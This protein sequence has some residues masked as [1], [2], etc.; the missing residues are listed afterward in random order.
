MG[1]TWGSIRPYLALLAASTPQ[2]D[3][4]RARLT[5]FLRFDPAQ[6]ELTLLNVSCYTHNSPFHRRYAMSILASSPLSTVNNGEMRTLSPTFSTLIAPM[7]AQL[8]HLSPLVSRS[9]RPLTY[10]FAHQVRA[11][12]YYHREAFTSGQDLLQ[13]A[14]EDPLARALMVPETGLGESTFYEANADRGS[15]QMFELLD[16]LTQQVSKRLKIA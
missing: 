3:Q 10:T 16:R 9:N 15:Q 12:V 11:L 2:R 4:N 5:K 6:C 7:E 13:A 8:P 14:H 1:S